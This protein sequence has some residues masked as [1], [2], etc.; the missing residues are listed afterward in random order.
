V[1]IE[2]NK[3]K[4]DATTPVAQA[5]TYDGLCGSVSGQGDC[6]IFGSAEVK[7]S[8]RGRTRGVML[9]LTDGGKRACES[10]SFWSVRTFLDFDR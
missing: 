2:L 9:C 1:T 5:M 4:R 6:V 8:D 3:T 10:A 7:E